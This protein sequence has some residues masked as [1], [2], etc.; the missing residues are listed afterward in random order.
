MKILTRIKSNDLI[1]T[2]LSQSEGKTSIELLSIKLHRSVSLLSDAGHLVFF[3]AQDHPF[4]E[5]VC[6][7][8]I[9]AFER[10]FSS[11]IHER[12]FIMDNVRF[13]KTNKIQTMRQENA[14]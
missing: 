10:F 2:Q 6:G 13:Y 7:P 12:I 5:H 4:K 1:F 9:E 14:H 11:G 8:L 3:E